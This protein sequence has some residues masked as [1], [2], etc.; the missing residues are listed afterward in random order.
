MEGGKHQIAACITL[1]LDRHVHSFILI[2]LT[3]SCA[4]CAAAKGDCGQPASQTGGEYPVNGSTTVGST[5]T[6]RCSTGYAV[7]PGTNATITCQSNGTWST[8]SSSP[9]LRDCR[10][11]N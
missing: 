5:R 4:M 3:V 10:R 9:C 2:L 8:H 7:N 6:I 1:R 11:P